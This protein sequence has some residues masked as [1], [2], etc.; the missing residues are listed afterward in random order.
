MTSE[1]SRRR[2]ITITKRDGEETLSIHRSLQAKILQD[3]EKNPSQRDKAFAQA[4]LL[5]RHRFPLPSP[6][7]VPTPDAW[8]ACI[9]YLRHVLSLRKVYH[10]N[11]VTIPPSVELAR[12]LSDGGIN[13]WERGMT[14]EGLQLLHSAEDILDELNLGSSEDM[15]RANVHVIVALLLQDYGM[16]H[17][18]ES[19]RRIWQALQ[20]RNAFYNSTPSKDYTKNDDILLHNAW[21]DHGCV[22][23]QYN[24]YKEAEPIF[25]RCLEKYREW[26]PEES[27][28]YEHAKYNHHMAFCKMYTGDY[29][30]AINL[31]EKG[32]K[33][34]ILATGDRSSSTHKWKFDLA[35]I[36]LQSGNTEKALRLH[37]EVLGARIL[38]HGKSNFQ[39]L[40]SYYAVGALHAHLGDHARAEENMRA[41][42]A[43]EPGRNDHYPEA[44]VARAEYHLSQLLTAQ[45]GRTDEAQALELHADT[46]LNKLLALNPNPLEGVETAS[47]MPFFDH[48]QPVFDGRFTGT[49]L[50]PLLQREHDDVPIT[51]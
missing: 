15:L 48:I 23:L 35:C 18:G 17:L 44:A 14:S 34:V 19:S 41:S 5:V 10:G 46:I 3:L 42:L 45:Y 51:I 37:E 30:D 29:E 16:S 50:L 32:L 21:S 31:G 28:P 26:G 47:A 8:P 4:F 43:L 27:I 36:V 33:F 24:N 11:L 49:E 22:L 20:I 39:T 6:I 25:R 1:L 13:L 12:L 38:Q 40:Q 7:Q 9:K 2:L